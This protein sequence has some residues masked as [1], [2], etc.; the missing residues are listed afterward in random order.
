MTIFEYITASFTILLGLAFARLLHAIPYVFTKHNRDF[1]HATLFLMTTFLLIFMWW[2]KWNFSSVQDWTYIKYFILLVDFGLM[3]MMC[4]AI[5]PS[6]SESISSW[7]E[8]IQKVK[9]LFFILLFLK[10]IITAIENI[11]MLQQDKKL[12]FGIGAILLCL[13]PAI[14]LLTK[15][16]KIIKIISVFLAIL[17]FSMGLIGAILTGGIVVQ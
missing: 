1:L 17:F 13:P 11:Y 3:F 10:F 2:V 15:S 6:N 8:H 7:S 9:N 4:D 5:A 14:A 16:Q 12:L